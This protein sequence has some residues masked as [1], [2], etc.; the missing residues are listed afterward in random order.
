M[1]RRFLS[2][3]LLLVVPLSAAAYS[4]AQA[5]KAREWVQVRSETPSDADECFK[6]DNPY[7]VCLYQDKKT[8]SFHF[9]DINLQ[10]P[11]APYYFDNGPDYASEGRYR[12]KI[13]DKIGFADSVS[14]KL[15]IPAI[16]ECAHPYSGG[17]A[18]VGVG[19]DRESDGEHSWW[20]NGY[21]LRIDPY[22]LITGFETSPRR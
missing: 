4:E 14:G 1:M 20:V 8:Y 21:W 11:Y 17:M 22:G 6:P 3:V 5:V 15:V 9:V 10:E 13:G 2:A 19:C 16:Y 7:Q 18:Q 12:V